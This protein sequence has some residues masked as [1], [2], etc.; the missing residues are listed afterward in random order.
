M[1]PF[2]LIIHGN[3]NISFL[4]REEIA[5]L[6]IQNGANVKIVGCSNSTALTLAA[7]NGKNR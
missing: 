2:N 7:K 3:E 4:G 5:K 6:L 1:S